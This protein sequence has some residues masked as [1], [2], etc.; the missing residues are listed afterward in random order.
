MNKQTLISLL[1]QLIK[2]I[3]LRHFIDITTFPFPS[4][5]PENV[6][7]YILLFS[8]NRAQLENSLCS[9]KQRLGCQATLREVGSCYKNPCCSLL[10]HWEF[11]NFTDS[12]YSPAAVFQN[13][14]CNVAGRVGSSCFKNRIFSELIN[15]FQLK[16]YM[17]T[18]LLTYLLVG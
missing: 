6:I 4:T 2:N 11:R 13:S 14:S 12:F 16:I 7:V 18:V 8:S 5:D 3:L 17:K 10:T 1:R 15:C 9:K